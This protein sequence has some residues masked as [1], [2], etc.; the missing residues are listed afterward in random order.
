M[1]TGWFTTVARRPL[2]VSGSCAMP[3]WR[4]TVPA[5]EIHALADQ[6]ILPEDEHRAEAHLELAAGGRESPEGA[7]VGFRRASPRRRPHRR[8]DE[9]RSARCAGPETPCGSRR[10]TRRPRAARRRHR[11]SRSARS[12]VV[13]GLESD[14]GLMPVLRLHVL[15]DDRFAL[16]T[17]GFGRRH[18]ATLSAAANLLQAVQPED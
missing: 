13:E 7:V 4:R 18:G 14:V 12:G 17:Q 8:S 3:S 5:F 10:S 11:L 9:A 15:D 1:V 2:S 16:V 6:P